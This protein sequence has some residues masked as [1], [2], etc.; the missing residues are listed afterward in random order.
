MTDTENEN[1]TPISL[2]TDLIDQET[3][4]Q[5][6]DMDDG[7]DENFLLDILDDYYK[8]AQDTFADMETALKK[9][10][11]KKLSELGHFLKGSS[12]AMGLTKVKDSCEKIQ[13]CGNKKDE[14]GKKDITE[15]DAL[16]RIT[17]LLVQVRTEYE[18]AEAHLKGLYKKG[19]KS[20]N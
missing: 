14:S 5:L 10:N 11:L 4:N 15:E 7:E 3:F 20:N 17:D 12:A 1:E 8:Q 13:H 18:S 2:D 16:I 9:K 6:L 19:E